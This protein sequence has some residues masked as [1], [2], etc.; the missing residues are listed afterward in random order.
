MVTVNIL[1]VNNENKIF[2]Y[3]I[4]SS[5][6]PEGL[7]E[8]DYTKPCLKAI[9][10]YLKDEPKFGQHCSVTEDF[11]DTVASTTQSDISIRIK[12]ANGFC[13]KDRHKI[14]NI[15]VIEKEF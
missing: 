2:K 6:F 12:F 7:A 9:D 5:D 10:N 3:K 11:W 8:G 15:Y 1:V 14:K 13:K 4:S